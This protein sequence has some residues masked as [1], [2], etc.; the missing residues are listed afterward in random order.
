M[1]CIIFCVV[2]ISKPKQCHPHAKL[3]ETLI[4]MGFPS[5]FLYSLRSLICGYCS[6][7]Q[8]VL[9]GPPDLHIVIWSFTDGRLQH[10]SMNG[11]S[12]QLLAQSPFLKRLNCPVFKSVAVPKPYTETAPPL[13]KDKQLASLPSPQRPVVRLEMQLTQCAGA[14]SG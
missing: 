2:K 4:E 6:S 7:F 12:F 5:G 13:L 8:M 14:V 11:S 1:A 10:S 9:R 3:V